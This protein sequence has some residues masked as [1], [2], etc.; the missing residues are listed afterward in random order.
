MRQSQT[1]KNS[2][3]DRKGGVIIFRRQSKGLSAKNAR[4]RKRAA[5]LLRRSFPGRARPMLAAP[6]FPPQAFVGEAQPP[7]L[8]TKLFKSR[9]VVQRRRLQG[10]EPSHTFTPFGRS[11]GSPVQYR[12][13]RARRRAQDVKRALRMFEHVQ[14]RKKAVERVLADDMM[15]RIA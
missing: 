1:N 10:S 11:R 4:N 3:C 15:G 7:I 14:A 13:Q 6:L 8:A 2:A 12:P 9:L 5:E